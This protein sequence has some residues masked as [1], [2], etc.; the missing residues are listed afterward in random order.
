M[1]TAKTYYGLGVLVALGTVFVIL[2]GI[3]ALGIVGDGGPPDLLY[4]GALVVGLVGAGIA[5]F[6]AGGMTLALAAAA[7]CTIL[8]AVVAVGAGLHDDAPA[9]DVFWLS[10]GFAAMFGLSAWLFSRAEAVRPG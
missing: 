5:R 7:G 6:R 2:F 8:A 3:A 4:V 9:T 10:G 1:S